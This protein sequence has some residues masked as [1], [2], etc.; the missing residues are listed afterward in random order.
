MAV[1]PKHK[2]LD[3]SGNEILADHFTGSVD[4]ESVAFSSTDFTA[5]NVAA[6]LQELFD[7]VD[8]LE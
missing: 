2:Q 5:T 4:A 8:G 7:T 6:A 1:Y 3:L